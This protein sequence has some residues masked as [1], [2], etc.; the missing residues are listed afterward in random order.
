MKVSTRIISGFG[1]LMIL[2]LLALG[3]QV[4]VIYQLQTTTSQQYRVNFRAVEIVLR[5]MQTHSLIDELS[6]KFFTDRPYY[7]PALP[8]NWERFETELSDLQSALAS[9]KEQ[10]QVA[11]LVEAWKE[12]RRQWDEVVKQPEAQI[13]IEDGQ[14]ILPYP[15]EERTTTVKSKLDGVQQEIQKSVTEQLKRADQV[16]LQQAKRISWFAGGMALVIGV[17]SLVIVR[18]IN[19]P[20]QQL[21]KSTRMIADGQFAHRLPTDS[22]DEFAELARDFNAMTQRLGELDQMKKDFV[23][24]VSHELKA[25]LAS[26]RQTAHLLLEQIPGPLNDQ[27]KKLL[28]LSY[29]SA[30]RLAAMVG[31]LLDLSRMEAGSME[32]AMTPVDLGLLAKTVAEEFEVQSAERSVPIR[33]SVDAENGAMVAC[34]RDRMIQVIG[35]L[36]DNALK[37]SPRGGEIAATI[38]ERANGS[39]RFVVFSVADSGPGVADDHK[40]RIF[41]KFH[42]VKHGKKISGQ[43]V[44]LGLAICRSI[45]EAH[46]GRIWVEDNPSGGSIFC[47]ELQAAPVEVATCR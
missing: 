17:V 47:V 10:A 27:Q 39:K 36:I 20:L 34:D 12:F 6:R 1:F 16:P 8:G 32:Y 28:R 5:M 37:F 45:V 15:L 26:I 19:K 2:A 40:E 31:N 33:V 3:Y 18:A 43:G 14:I 42:Q 23:S 38:R 13:T 30:E 7:E 29:N 4:W 41:R 24:H 11:S 9:E 44:G 46:Q 25:P 22:R 35:N 21:T